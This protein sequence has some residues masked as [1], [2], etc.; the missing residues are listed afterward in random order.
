MSNYNLGELSDEE[1]QTLAKCSDPNLFLYPIQRN[2]RRYMQYTSLLGN[3]NKKS[4]L[5]QKNLP[6]IAVKL[7]RKYDQN[8]LKAM[9]VSAKCL[10]EEFE[11]FMTQALG[12]EV[13]QKELKDFSSRDLIN[14]IEKYIEGHQ[15]NIDLLWLQFK[16]YGVLISDDKKE[17][18][19]AYMKKRHEGT[20]KRNT[21]N[22]YNNSKMP[23]KIENQIKTSD[24]VEK[25]V[26]EKT[27]KK[28][29]KE[30]AEENKER[31]R[32]EKE[33]TKV[34]CV[35]EKEEL[36]TKAAEGKTIKELR[37]VMN[38]VGINNVEESSVGLYVGRINIKSNYYNFT[39]IGEIVG[40]RYSILKEGEIDRLLPA[41]Q[42]RNIN[43]FYNIWDE[44][45]VKFM[46]DHFYEGQYVLFEF[47]VDELQENKDSSGH[48]NP[49]GYKVAGV[50]F[51]Q[52]GKIRFLSDDGFYTLKHMDVLLDDLETHKVV[53]LLYDHI[54][55]G[56]KILINLKNNFY[57][58]PYEI[59]YNAPGAYYYI[60]PFVVENKYIIKGVR[61]EDCIREVIEEEFRGRIDYESIV[62]YHI[63]PEVESV[64]RDVIT[65]K[66][67]L[68]SFIDSVK[69]SDESW[70]DAGKVDAVIQNYKDS[71]LSANDLPEIIK[72]GRIERLRA[73]LSSQEKQNEMISSITDI[74][75]EQIINN[76]DDDRIG[77]LVNELVRKHPEL[78]ENFQSLRM[79]RDRVEEA[80]QELKQLEMKK[81]D[82]RKEAQAIK[83]A[84]I[85]QSVVQEKSEE[86]Q[87]ITEKLEVAY[88]AVNLQ[89][90]VDTLKK[91]V[92]YYARRKD[93]LDRDTKDLEGSF[94]DLVNRYSSRIADI[95][96]DGFMSS[97]MLQSAAN[98]EEEEKIKNL[99]ELI[100][101][102]NE[103][104]SK[105]WTSEQLIDYLVQTVQIARP[106][107]DRNA[108]LNLFICTMQGF[109]TVFS[110]A[111]GCGKTSICNILA[112][113]LGLSVF[114]RIIE[115]N[116][117]VGSVN[118]YIPVSV[119]RGWTS[120]R[121]LIGYYN[122]LTKAFEESNREVFEGLQG[123]N[124]E[125][126]KGLNRFPFII[127]LDEANLSS[128]EYY[129]ADFMNICDDLTDNHTINLGNN[130]I[131]TVPETLHF[132][133][134]IN[135]DPTTETLSPRLIDRAWIITLPKS[136]VIEYGK[137]I[138]EEKIEIIPW[139]ILK[140][141]FNVS[142]EE[143]FGLPIDIQRIYEDV[144][145]HL[146]KANIIIS[147]RVD[148]AVKSYI[149]VA[150]KIM[151]DDEFGNSA[152]IVALDYA[153]S[154]K[155][156]PKIIGNGEEYAEWLKEFKNLCTTHGMLKSAQI[157]EEVIVNGI[158]Q[159]KYFQFF[160]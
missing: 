43:L 103:V 74:V 105:E 83:E 56:E 58:G 80:E 79:L 124:I 86:L 73:I 14:A 144:R 47:S 40:K 26:V 7:F 138:P 100:V 127:L 142:S 89:E 137:E 141:T 18:V 54:V 90:K 128:M 81:E 134:T 95:T 60:R 104:S 9:D 2:N 110:G 42:F 22:T 93:H 158:R 36:Q 92:D 84:A 39:P 49:T 21:T 123:L 32:V 148:R 136:S 78:I 29:A 150:S 149:L 102:V 50:D 109:L 20:E 75:C 113:V 111:P 53:K 107:Y 11:E 88:E 23:A 140:N 30:K 96:F 146:H 63:K 15:L 139:E 87:K 122:P 6:G 16:L 133:A 126:R 1:L 62:V 71:V 61:P 76:G 91:E 57:A 28:T 116:G 5:V 99:N 35:A 160:Y 4:P 72:S 44:K 94:L 45:H 85:Y 55:E 135:N 97:K 34:E 108:I 156:L 145:K 31:K 125:S 157:L 131:F 155:I 130:N 24:E 37:N 82:I 159:M 69:N 151:C 147:Y 114:D 65:D 3:L 70:N 154:Q 25:V 77:M 66:A 121:D 46:E 129:W 33:K 106:Q 52:K 59:K 41:S 8:F 17:E 153:I 101:K 117:T 120:K 67:L 152:K 10:V 38:N 27:S 143:N 98:W 12:H 48:L 13:T 68:E 119:E 132:L 112:K 19:V 64:C 51:T 115:N 118:R